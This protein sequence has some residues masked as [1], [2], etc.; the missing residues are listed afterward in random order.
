MTGVQTCALPIY[1]KITDTSKFKYLCSYMKGYAYQVIEHLTPSDESYQEALEILKAEF[2]DI[3]YILEE[4]M[5][6]IL[7]DKPEY[8]ITYK[9][10]KLYL[11]SLK[12]LLFE[13]KQHN[14]D[15]MVP[16]SPGCL[17]LSSIVFSKLP[18]AFCRELTRLT[19][20]RKSTRLNS[21]HRSLSRMPSSA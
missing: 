6:K 16:D 12:T 20:D 9:N 11:I 3:P 5:Q 17:L 2:L 8:D 19:K 13:L 18:L 21:S 15:F 4:S 7:K 14:Y 10:L 1:Q